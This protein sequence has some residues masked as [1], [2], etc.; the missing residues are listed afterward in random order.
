MSVFFSSVSRLA[1]GESWS[2]VKLA[3]RC[4][5]SQLKGETLWVGSKKR[6]KESARLEETVLQPSL[7]AG[8][9]SNAFLAQ[10]DMS[11]DEENSL[12]GLSKLGVHEV[13]KT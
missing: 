8:P 3:M 10:V 6:K 1:G 5:E 13:S 11:D 7:F 4:F 12:T 2:T 9:F